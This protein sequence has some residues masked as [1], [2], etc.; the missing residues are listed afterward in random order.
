[1]TLQQFVINQTTKAERSPQILGLKL[2]HYQTK[3]ER[4]TSLKIQA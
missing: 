4:R 3:R 1:M 2:T